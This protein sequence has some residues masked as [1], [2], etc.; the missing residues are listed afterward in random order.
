M[1]L[2]K[3]RSIII[4]CAIVG[5]MAT[6]FFQEPVHLRVYA[7]EYVYDSLNRVIKVIY[8][9]GGYVEYVYD[10]NGNIVKT[11]VHPADK[12]DKP[13]A[14][15]SGK[16]EK[17][18]SS[19]KSEKSESNKEARIDRGVETDNDSTQIQTPAEDVKNAD[20]EI[21]RGSRENVENGDDS[22]LGMIFHFI[23]N[24]IRIIIE[25]A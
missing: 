3:I 20:L 24:F 25:R 6:V 23:L 2:R 12:P 1:N 15:E 21:K 16:G 18:E 13:E 7:E 10:R 14:V 19:K 9:D 8:E 11:V 5:T 22:A 4:T 17:T